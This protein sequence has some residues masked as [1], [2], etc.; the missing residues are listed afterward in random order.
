M[1]VMVVMMTMVPV[2]AVVVPMT[3]DDHS[4]TWIGIY[5]R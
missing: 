4:G 5:Y 1:M 3:N 2:M